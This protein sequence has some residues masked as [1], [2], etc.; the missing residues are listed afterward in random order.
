MVGRFGFFFLLY[1]DILDTY[2]DFMSDY[3][4][5]SDLMQ[6]PSINLC[7]SRHGASVPEIPLTP[8]EKEILAQTSPNSLNNPSFDSLSRNSNVSA[9][10]GG[11]GGRASNSSSVFSFD[12]ASDTVD[13]LLMPP[14]PKPPLPPGHQLLLNRCA[15]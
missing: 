15:G 13:G 6:C 5:R 12:S 3:S 14:P 11:G 2:S 7:R 10:S 4:S 8:R 1:S 9:L